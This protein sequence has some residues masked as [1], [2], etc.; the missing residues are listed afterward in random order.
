MTVA[1]DPGDEVTTVSNE[2]T[3][4]ESDPSG[5]TTQVA[6]NITD[7]VTES[8]TQNATEKTSASNRTHIRGMYEKLSKLHL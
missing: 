8:A 3:L 4:G 2:V 5:I 6:S 1:P 7:I